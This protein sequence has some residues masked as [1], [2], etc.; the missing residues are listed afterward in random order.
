MIIGNGQ[1]LKGDCLELML[2]IP[3]GSVDMICTDVP[4]NAVNR[5]SSGLRNLDKG[6]ADSA[7][8]DMR[9]LVLQSSRVLKGS[10]YVFCGREQIGPL[11]TLMEE[12]GLTVRVGVW[13]KTNPSPMNGEKLWLSGLEFCVFGRKP[14]ATFNEHCKSPLWSFASQKSKIHPTQ[15]PIK[16]FEHLIRA[17]SNPG[18]LVLDPFAGSGTAAIAAENAG[19]RWTCIERDP[20]YYE[21]AVG[22]VSDHVSRLPLFP[23]HSK[24]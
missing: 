20:T 15:K 4:Y 10:A 24:P 17:S 21:A 19:R 9:A 11:S 22:R 8:F 2:E 13:Q 7:E 1:F 3:D 12:N 16:L 5:K 23:D 6:I 18:D 14:K